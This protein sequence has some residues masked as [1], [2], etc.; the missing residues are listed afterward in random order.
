MKGQGLEGPVPSVARSFH[1]ID[2]EKF[3]ST[4]LHSEV[5]R[6]LKIG[7][8]VSSLDGNIN[9]FALDHSVPRLIKLLTVAVLFPLEYAW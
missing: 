3:G 2:A 6:F 7:Y 9:G 4:D 5:L 1:A 8:F